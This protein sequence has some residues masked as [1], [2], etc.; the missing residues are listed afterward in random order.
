MKHNTNR[1]MK[2]ALGTA[3]AACCMAVTAIDPA[4]LLTAEAAYSTGTYTV[5]GQSANIRP[6]PG[7]EGVG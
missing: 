2:R 1:S 5:S 6:T 3:L 4:S 7:E